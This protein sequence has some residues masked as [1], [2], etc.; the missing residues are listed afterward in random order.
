[1]LRAPRWFVPALVSLAALGCEPPAPP[2]APAAPSPAA[3]PAPT[4]TAPAQ[5]AAA[6]P[7]D[8][9]PREALNRIAQELFLPL[10]WAGDTNRSGAIDPDEVVGLWG[11]REAPRWVENGQFTAA[12]RGAFE[13]IARVHARGYD[14]AGLP[15]GE[16]RRRE[17]VRQELAQ[18]RPSLVRTDLREA[19][20]EDRELVRRVMAAAEIVE[21]IHA[22][23]TGAAGLD[24]GLGAG[25]PAGDP[26]SRALFWRNQGPWCEQPKTGADPACHALGSKPPRISGLYPAEIQEPGFCEA[27]EKRPDQEALLAP[28][29]VVVKRGEGLAAVPYSEAYREEMEAVSRE[30]T[31][32]AAAVKSPGE[33]AL[34]AY[35]LAAAQAFRDN[36]WE[37]SDEAW[38]KM[39]AEN[40]RWYLRIGPDEVGADPC[41]RKAGFHVS[42]ARIN[43]DSIALQRKL[44]PLK[45]DM[46]ASLAKLAGPPYRA[47]KV[48]FHLPDFIDIVLNAGDSRAAAGGTA[49]QSLPNWGPVANEGRGRTVAMVNLF[50]DPDSMA[51]LRATVESLFCKDALPLVSVEPGMLTMSTVLHEAAHNLGPSHEYRVKG[52]RDSE[53]FG[54]GLAAMLEELKAQTAAMYFQSWLVDRGVMDRAAADRGLA[55]DMVWAFGQIKQGMTTPDGKPAPYAQLSAI[56]V[57]RLL[58]AGAMEWRAEELAGNGQDKGCFALRMERFPATVEALGREVLGI[59][60]RGDKAAALRL[61]EAYVDRPTA[62]KDA[63]RERGLRS[64]KATLVYSVVLR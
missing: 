56:Q 53:A 44:D 11:P 5:A 52:K 61:K 37:L 29:T 38:A 7:L 34:R 18:G 39:N 20:E 40:S 47:R 33:A 41:A 13:A 55:R 54:G 6:T 48:S 28:F 19:S 58:D 8:A 4:G 51:A 43:Q 16:R 2:A 12:F 35:L 46:E 27:L 62:W 10:F 1:M 26:A 30:L 63:I 23:Q 57:G 50:E 59:K 64:P 60:A 32:A 31:A 49:G 42:F 17:V 45:G 25:D 36:R 22:K 15:E 24:A 9:V 21:R 14:E 3:S